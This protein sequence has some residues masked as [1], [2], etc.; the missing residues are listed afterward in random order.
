MDST[1]DFSMGNLDPDPWIRGK[2]D[3]TGGPYWLGG[4]E[5][6]KIGFPQGLLD[7]TRPG[8]FLNGGEK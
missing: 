4:T 6:P 1:V 5:W 8:R 3:P 7:L 2:L